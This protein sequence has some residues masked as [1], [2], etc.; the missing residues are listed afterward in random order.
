MF[1]L[2]DAVFI[3]VLDRT[4]SLMLNVS[5]TLYLCSNDSSVE[6]VSQQQAVKDNLPETEAPTPT[7]SL[8]LH[9]A[10]D[11]LSAPKNSHSIA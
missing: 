4:S 10:E 8:L 7:A 1:S 9:I 3:Q 11:Q 5:G 2:W 6:F